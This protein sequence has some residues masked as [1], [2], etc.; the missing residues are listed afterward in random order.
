MGDFDVIVVG[1]GLAGTA[2]AIKLAREGARVALIERTKAATQKVCGDFL[3]VEAQQLLTHLGVD[4]AELGA[5]QI[6]TL[7]LVSGELRA[8]AKLPFVASGLSR[9]TLDE[10]L[11]AK[12]AAGGVEILR[13]EAATEIKAEAETASVRVGSKTLRSRWAGLATG[14]HNMR[15]WP[16]ANG[17][18]TAFKLQ[19][20]PTRNTAKELE[21]V[22]QLASYP[23][24]YI[25]ACNVDGGLTTICWLADQRLMRFLGPD[26]RTHLDH[27]SRRSSA[28]GGLLAGAQLVS[29]RPATVSGIP[30]GYMRR[31]VI[32]PNV[33]PLGDQLCVIPSF[34]G[35]GT[36]LAL[37][38]AIGAANTILRSGNAADFQ[39]AFLKHV[40]RQFFYA[41]AVDWTFQH[42]TTRRLA[43]RSVRVMPSLARLCARLTRARGVSELTEPEAAE[44]P[45]AQAQ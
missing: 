22:V 2:F 38:S 23:G 12:A 39:E 3:S 19:L 42:T 40:R 13:G 11:L 32:A 6:R 10:A 15:G 36:S 27:L 20:T 44:A 45:K 26:W 30:Y 25:G 41:S 1:G 17:A 37:L 35:D 16:R 18:M 33:F 7:R 34:T 4:I 28:I 5:T 8:N 31:D 9:V 43:V 14:K 29:S 21:G 24:G